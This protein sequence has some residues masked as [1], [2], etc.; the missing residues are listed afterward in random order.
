M[1]RDFDYIF[2]IRPSMKC[3]FRCDYCTRD[4]H[5]LDPHNHDF[6]ISSILWHAQLHPNALFS[7]C[8][9]GETM[10]HPQFADM[11]IE[12]SKVS[13]VDFI[14]NGTCFGESFDKI[15]LNANLMNINSVGIS[16]H[17]DQVHDVA[18]YSTIIRNIRMKLGRC[19]IHTYITAIATDYNYKS[20]IY[21]SRYFSDLV[22]SYPTEEFIR[23]GN[24]VCYA[25]SDETKMMLMRAGIRPLSHIQ[26][27]E[28]FIGTVCPNGSM[29]FEVGETGIIY[30]CSFDENRKIIGNINMKIEILKLPIDR[31][32]ASTSRQCSECLRYSSN[33]LKKCS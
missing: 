7:F 5:P 4:I 27:K 24:V 32:C 30:D 2:Y 22:V 9:H 14:T 10:M 8:G 3:N 21:G 33:Q 18:K 17:A 12:I 13:T 6:D 11:I 28:S 20:L 31:I 1:R 26:P 16:Y 23:D 29:I 19:G 15:M 25:V